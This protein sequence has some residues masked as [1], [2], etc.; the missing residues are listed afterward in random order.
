[1]IGQPER[2]DNK[3]SAARDLVA[4]ASAGSGAEIAKQT[5][6]TL[7]E[8]SANEIKKALAGTGI[9][10]MHFV[11]VVKTELS[12]TPKLMQCTPSSFLGAVLT[13]AQLG[14]EFGP[15]GQAYM[16]PR[17]NRGVD[18]VQLTI[19]YKGWAQLAYNSGQIKSLTA[20][21]VYENDEFDYSRGLEERLHHVPARENRGMAIAYYA[22]IRTLAGGVIWEVLTKEEAIAHMKKHAPKSD[23]KVVGP[24]ATDF[25][26]MARKTAFLRAKT[27]SPVG[28][29]KITLAST[30]DEGFVSRITVDEEPE[31]VFDEDEIFDGEIV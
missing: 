13:V 1:M 20:Q 2:T 11:R 24:W 6:K 14:L 21:V 17:K 18:E 27:W 23:G 22:I 26:A 5:N 19:G 25:D 4:A 3:A 9:D 15:M 28:S 10:E 7:V 30:V 12:K 31:V 29:T 8:A 16:I